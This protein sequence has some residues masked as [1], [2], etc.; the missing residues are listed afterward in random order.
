MPTKRLS[1][2]WMYFAKKKL[3]LIHNM[4]IRVRHPQMFRLWCISLQQ[5]SQGIRDGPGVEIVECSNCG[6]TISVLW[7]FYSLYL[8]TEHFMTCG[9]S[10]I[11]P[12]NSNSVLGCFTESLNQSLFFSG[13]VGPR[14]YPSVTV[15]VDNVPLAA[16]RFQINNS[17]HSI[18]FFCNPSLSIIS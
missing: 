11:N 4:S 5:F 10:N 17:T 2:S 3:F 13:L 16:R 1:I 18:D 14:G 6:E 15:E 9:V 8:S 12:A 7:W